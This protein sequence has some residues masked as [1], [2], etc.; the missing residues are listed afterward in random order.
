MSDHTRRSALQLIGSAPMG[1]IAFGYLAGHAVLD[2]M[3]F[4]P[5]AY[6]R[7]LRAVGHV[8]LADDVAERFHVFRLE[9]FG[10]GFREV[11]FRFA[12]TTDADPDFNHKVYLAL[13]AERDIGLKT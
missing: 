1:A 10:S 5:E 6:I 9:G 11:A 2:V 13:K 8:F 12:P 7:Q 4:S 3:D